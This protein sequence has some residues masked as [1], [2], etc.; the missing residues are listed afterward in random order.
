[1]APDRATPTRLVYIQRLNSAGTPQWTLDGVVGVS[2]SLVS[3]EAGDGDVHVTWWISSNTPV[4]I[5]RS[6][7]NASWSRVAAA[8]PDGDGL[9]SY[10]DRDITAGARYGYR[11]SFVVSGRTV[12][13]GETWIDVPSTVTFSLEGA[14][15]NPV[16]GDFV[17]SF[18]MQNGAPATHEVFQN[19]TRRIYAH[20][21]TGLA[22]GRHALSSTPRGRARG[23]VLHEAGRRRFATA[24]RG[25]AVKP[26]P[27]RVPRETGWTLSEARDRLPPET[28]VR[29]RAPR[30]EVT[31]Q[32]FACDAL[33]SGST[34][35]CR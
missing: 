21:F 23:P 8:L 33:G 17:A 34:C 5:E 15:P 14:R 20:T 27:R 32:E 16:T 10:D 31:L 19:G 12:V 11:V 35:T 13:A 28:G 1:L 22:A 26:R 4:T 7:D 24:R 9:V 2:A 30:L 25:P 29:R 3:A 6:T 18:T